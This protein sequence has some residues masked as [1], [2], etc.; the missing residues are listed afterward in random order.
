MKHRNSIE[1]WNAAPP[2]FS[3]STPVSYNLSSSI[4]QAYGSNLKQLTSLVPKFAVYSGDENQNG[5]INLSDV[6]NVS[7]EASSFTS[8]YVSSDMNGDNIT[9]L[10]D[11]VLTSNNASAFVN[12]LTP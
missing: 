11:L 5:I 7:N 4:T 9:D 12:N 2:A 8:G 10:S 6:V 3:N 1:T